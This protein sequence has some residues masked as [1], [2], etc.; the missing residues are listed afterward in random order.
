MRYFESPDQYEM[1]TY[2]EPTVFLAGGITDCPDWQA[3]MVDLLDDAYRRLHPGELDLVVFNPRRFSFRDPKL[4][5]EQ[6]EWEFEH[7][8]LADRILFWFPHSPPS[9]CPIS[10]FEL[11][12]WLGQDKR[13]AV[14]VEPGYVREDDVRIQTGLIRPEVPIVSTLED[15]AE[16]IQ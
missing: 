13:L 2:G 3:E 11:G 15:L 6:I 14:G 9:V 8:R 7:L 10:L 5:D 1:Y 12:Y 4:A 16:A